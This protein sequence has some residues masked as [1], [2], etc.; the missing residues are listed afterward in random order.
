MNME[1]RRLGNI[2]VY[3]QRSIVEFDGGTMANWGKKK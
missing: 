1:K 3:G 2:E